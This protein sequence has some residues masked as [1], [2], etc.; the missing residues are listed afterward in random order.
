[1]DGQNTPTRVKG[2][3]CIALVN[4]VEA[5]SQGKGVLQPY[6][7]SILERCLRLVQV[8]P[9]LIKERAIS[10]LSSVAET[11]QEDFG[12]FYGVVMPLL[13]QVLASCHSPQQ[14]LLHGKTLECISLV[15]AT[16]GKE[17]FGVDALA[18][19]ETMVQAQAGGL[20]DD[21]PT[22]VYM[23]R[24]WVRIC[25]CLGPD[26][27]PYLPLV[28]PPLLTAAAAK[29]E[30]DLPPDERAS[31]ELGEVDDVDSDVDCMEGLDGQVV[32]VRTCL[33]EEQ[34]TACQMLLLLAEALQEHFLPYVEVVSD[35]LAA[36]VNT[37]PHDD[38]RTF[39]MAGLPELVRSCGKAAAMHGSDLE[40]SGVR[41]LLEFFLARLMDS[42]QQETCVELLM[43]AVQAVKRCVQY[44]CVC[45]EN[46]TGAGMGDLGHLQPEICRPVLNKAQMDLLVTNALQCLGQSF[47]RRALRRAEATV[48][49]DWD[50][51]EEER[52]AE[53]G[54]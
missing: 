5:C 47:R 20:D 46:H 54:K 4:V 23:L 18:V 14:R 32:A 22:K 11:A 44:A 16:V 41:Q 1:M 40:L 30:V 21:D 12:P 9:L 15:G 42:L 39:C 25:K 50:E 37:S 34:A 33:L 7:N 36:L 53:A 27:A 51:E 28:M 26:F 3:A 17:R 10:V 48:S 13:K 8:G 35:Q 38:V 6:I 43:T 49:E 19:M 45:W 29:V 31:G 52:A 24:A 2:M